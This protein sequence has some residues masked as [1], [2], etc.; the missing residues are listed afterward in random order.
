M[1]MILY[2]ENPQELHRNI[3]KTKKLANT[4]GK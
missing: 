4:K 3:I 1:K 2:I